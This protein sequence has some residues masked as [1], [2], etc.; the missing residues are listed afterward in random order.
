MTRLTELFP[1]SLVA[2]QMPRLGQW[3]P[4]PPST[5]HRAWA[6]INDGTRAR[7][8]ESAAASLGTPWPALPASSYA[9]FARDGDRWD[10]QTPAFARRDRL[11][12]AVLATAA[13]PATHGTTSRSAFLD[14]VMDGVWALC[15]ETSWCWPAHDFRILGSHD[16]R[17]GLLP[18]PDRP[19]LDLGASGTALLLALTDAVVGD[20]LDQLD[21]LVRRRLRRE[22]SHRVLRPYLERD[23][24]GWYDGSTAK[25]NNWNPWIHSEL[26]LAT[27]LTEE[28]G[29]RRTALMCRILKGLEN[30]LHAHPRDGGCDEGPHYWWRAGAS[31]FECLE[32]ISSLLGTDAGVFDEPLIRAMA[33]YPLATWIG[34]GWVVNFADGPA[35]PREMTAAVM[36]RY[37]LRTRQPDVTAHA[38][39]LRADAD[40]ALPAPDAPFDLRRTLDALFDSGWQSA[41]PAAFPLPRRTWLPDTEVLVARTSAGTER[42]L[43]LAAKGGHNDESHNHNDVGTFIIALDSRPLLIDA[44]VGTYRKETFSSER[45]GIWS[46]TSEFHNVPRVN[47]VGQAPGAAYRATAV[48]HHHTADTDELT[49]DLASAYPPQAQLEGWPR[50]LRLVH[51]ETDEHIEIADSWRCTAP[52]SSLALHLL[53]SGDLAITAEDHATI[54][55]A[56]GRGLTLHWD[57]TTFT[58]TAEPI[59][60]ADPA[61]T[62]VWG[63]VI[64]RL[65]LTA[66]QPVATAGRHILT[67]R[68]TAGP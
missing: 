41:P 15:E 67:I 62:R 32:T 19:T 33:R 1:P 42:G 14:D 12:R 25:L 28:S 16:G 18:D 40:A 50:T 13:S 6:A 30:Y 65:I 2:A 10:Y 54:T 52:P 31:V 38:R 5:D 55:P 27:A 59:P 36:Y 56:A 22:I 39:A 9:R 44:G 29:D 26:L 68:P 49:C 63:P 57:A 43:L 45:Y 11:A 24:W 17:Q 4:V 21:L 58:G 61:F 51:G 60:L 35:R 64:H 20:E 7:I 23:D 37:G 53:V 46:M 34:G 66:Q 48:A 3:S 47:G 8:V